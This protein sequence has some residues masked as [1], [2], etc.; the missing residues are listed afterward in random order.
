MEPVIDEQLL[1]W[2]RMVSSNWT[3]KP[4]QSR[5]FDIGKRF[6]FLTVDIIT[7]LCLGTALGCVASDSDMYDFLATVKQGNSICQHSSALLKLNSP[8]YYLAK[9]PYL[10][11]LLVPKPTDRSGVG[12]I[13]GVCTWFPIVGS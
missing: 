4:G 13:M 8:M 7:K 9:N 2:L 12:R 6:Q 3:S 1:D 11:P 10:G 5:S